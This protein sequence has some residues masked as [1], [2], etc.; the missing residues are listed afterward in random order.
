MI[1]KRV[2]ALWSPK[3]GTG[4]SFLTAN[5]GKYSSMEGYLTGVIDLNRQY[6]SLPHILN[7]HPQKNKSLRNALFTDND[8]DV[9]I[10]FQ[11]NEKNQKY[12]F[13]LGLNPG[14]SV[15]D[16]HEL[17]RKDIERLYQ[18]AKEKFNIVFLDLPTSY[19]EYTSYIGW[20][21][22]E[23]IIVV[24]DNDINSLFA[25]RKYLKQFEELNIKKD[26]LI[27]VVNKDIGIISKKDIK[28]ITGLD[29]KSIIPFS[30]HIVMDSNEGKTIFDAGGNFKDRY[31]QNQIKYIFEELIEKEV[32]RGR[33]YRKNRFLF[34]RRNE[35]DRNRNIWKEVG[36]S[37]E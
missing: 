3:P 17:E 16:L 23:K 25:L 11:E 30:K 8:R 13:V 31:I 9:I 37:N 2:F 33:K 34:R 14:D 19:I 10:N 35:E 6:S 24:I 21:F 26:K 29:V 22:A 7:I 36:G 20:F 18:I 28:L 27:L 15:D 5:L 1:D 4:T 12:L 32:N